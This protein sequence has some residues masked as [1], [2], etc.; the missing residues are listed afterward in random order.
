MRLN[1]LSSPI[2]KITLF[3]RVASLVA[4]LGFTTF[5][6]PLLAQEAES[7]PTDALETETETDVKEPAPSWPQVFTLGDFTYSI[8]KP[9]LDTWD[10]ETLKAWLA[11]EVSV[12]DEETKIPVFGVIALTASTEVDEA[13]G[14]VTLSDVKA[15]TVDFPTDPLQEATMVSA[16]RGAMP[17]AAR[18]IPLEILESSLAIEE[19]KQK[20]SEFPLQNTPPRIVFSDEPTMLLLLSGEPVLES[21]PGTTLKRVANT[22]A[23]MLIDGDGTHYLHF[24]DGWLEAPAYSGPWKIAADPPTDLEKA[25]ERAVE[26][27]QVD[28]LAGQPDPE[29][30]EFPSLATDEP[31]AIL[32]ATRP[33]ELIVTEEEPKWVNLGT[34]GLEYVENTPA[35]WFRVTETGDH[36]LLLS[37]RWFKSQDPD[38]GAWTYVP[39]KELP[40]MFVEIPDESDKENVKASVPGT[41]QAEE[42]FI[43]NTVP[44]TELI[45]VDAQMVSQPEILGAEPDLRPIEGT[46]LFYV[47]NSE[48]PIIKV[49]ENAW[50]AVEDGAWYVAE[51]LDG[52]WAVATSVPADIY[53]IPPSSPLY[54]VTY[55][56][57]YESDEEV[58]TTG[59]YPGYYGAIPTS[60][61]TVVYGTGYTY[62]DY[63]AP[64]AYVAYPVTYGYLS[65]I[66]WTPWAGWYCGFGV[67]VAWGPRYRYWRYAPPAPYWGGYFRVSYGYGYYRGGWG[68]RG[69]GYRGW[70]PYRGYRG[71]TAAYYSARPGRATSR[72]AAYNP[73]TG[74]AA[75]ARYRYSFNSRTGNS[76][77][78]YRARSENVFTGNY[79]KTATGSRVNPIRGTTTT[80]TRTAVGNR[81]TGDRGSVA[82]ATRTNIRNG[83]VTN[84]NA[85]SN[86]QG[87]VGN[88]N[89]VN[90]YTGRTRSADFAT[91]RRG[92]VARTQSGGVFAERNGR[93]YQRT[94]S[95]WTQ[96]PNAGQRFE[97]AN[98][99]KNRLGGGRGGRRR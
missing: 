1:D 42:A 59:V 75:N 62:T 25:K 7:A 51:S 77:A 84:V 86:R 65:N 64:A 61:G 9:Q 68:Y 32:V 45:R 2:M 90:A 28:L 72:V 83:N 55:V 35:N 76:T 37:G 48:T 94:D 97:R 49:D 67:G 53:S 93:V 81:F 5:T 71:T 11:V 58:V 22:R 23:L 69:Y 3:T 47:A 74:N 79:T 54:F 99:V 80:A 24:F 13:N 20:A 56:R 92:T 33:T 30:D 26:R 4:F 36:F 12:A 34:T 15:V 46:T 95:G 82:S 50:Y 18:T 88:V 87:T 21:V 16:L 66:Y 10:G 14:L 38:L 89:R 8:N 39:G 41:P 27:R 40:E 52:P 6:S 73:Y 70:G 60:G 43:A 98:N 29:T 85:A 19:A 78:V 57:V 63:V 91:S 44:E 96:R 31:P 17:V